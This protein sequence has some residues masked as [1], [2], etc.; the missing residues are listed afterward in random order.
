MKI[1]PIQFK[2]D[3]LKIIDQ[4]VIPAE[5]KIISLNS[6]NKSIEAINM[7]RI[8]GAPAIG[9][10]AAY[11][12]FL[13]TKKQLLQGVLN[14]F[15]FNTICTKLASTRPT[16]YNLFWAI[17]EMKQCFLKYKN[18]RTG[19]LEALKSKALSIHTNDIEMCERIGKF[20][21]PLIQDYNNIITHCNAGIFATGGN[22]T[23]LSVIYEAFKINRNLHVYVDETRPLGQGARLTYYELE[24][25][26]VKCTLIVDSSSGSLCAAKKI[27]A[28]IVGADRICLNG[29]FAN[30][31]GTFNLAVLAKNF[32]IPFFVA[33]PSSTFDLKLKSG[34]SINIESRDKS[35]ILS[36]WNITLDY[37]V[38]NPSF[39]ITPG[40]YV[41]G[42]ITDFGIIKKPYKKNILKQLKNRENVNE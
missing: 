31:I 36:M 18:D 27:D 10:V 41:T 29:D 32:N 42:F 13:E 37:N 26:K 1:K 5:L 39:D 20:G 14:D 12:I 2:N 40:D 6:L 19:L 38:Y 22:G 34:K 33:A 25:H 3:R 4:T 16:A 15:S 28:V 8:R 9:I 7:L 21:A 24:M 17:E 11:T 30:K 35:E 23:A